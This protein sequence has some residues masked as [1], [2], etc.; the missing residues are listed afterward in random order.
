MLLPALISVGDSLLKNLHLFSW[1]D[2]TFLFYGLSKAKV[3]ALTIPIWMIFFCS[4]SLIAVS[5]GCSS[6]R[7]LGFSSQCFLLLQSTG[8]RHAGFSS[9][10]TQAQELWLM[11]SRV[12]VQWLW[13]MG[14]VALWHVGSSWSRDRTPIPCVG[15]LILIH[16]A[17][18]DVQKVCFL[19]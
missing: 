7:R 15:R 6:F 4:S 8:S 5:R 9:C 16:C 13:S 1:Q 11:G 17:T 14:L 18:R 12:R 19:K 2:C 3:T 10:G